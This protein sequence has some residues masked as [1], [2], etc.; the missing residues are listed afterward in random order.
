VR[1]RFVLNGAKHEEIPAPEGGEFDVLLREWSPRLLAQ[2]ARRYGDFALAED[3]VQ[4][5]IIAAANQW[6]VE[7]RPDHPEAWLTRVATRRMI[8]RI[9]S[10]VARRRREA[11]LARDDNIEH[12]TTD[13]APQSQ[14]DDTLDLLIMCCHPAL[15][16][17]SA[18]ALTLRALCGLTTAEIANAF[19]V[20]ESTMAQRIS[21]AKQTIKLHGA[22]FEM[23]SP[24]TRT[25]RLST[26][27]HVLHLMFNEGYVA[28]SGQRAQRLDLTNEA[29]RLMREVWAFAP[30][31]TEAA[32]LLALMLLTDARR[33]ARVDAFGALVP[34]LDQDRSAWDH[35][36]IKE[37]ISLISD[38]LPKG[39]VGPYQ[40]MAA[41]AAVHDEADLAEATDWAQIVVLY[42][43]LKR[44][45]DNPMVVLNQAVAVAMVSGARAGLSLLERLA[46]DSRLTQHHRLDAVRAHLLERAGDMRGA[47]EH[48]RRAALHTGSIPERDF[49]L[50]SAARLASAVN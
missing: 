34:L 18:M 11:E 21:R 1:A 29:I 32:G 35:A 38:T 47:I 26:V 20:P 6:P 27:L 10:D 16:P 50:K 33:P 3:A 41:I 37:G 9:R 17:P 8:D 40:I 25:E 4:D 15:S 39:A 45:T 5:A 46:D 49:L 14:Q 30:E 13:C 36:L 42:D 7:G 44:M 12:K 31:N 23:P 43:V 22:S 24:A 2:L 19:F 28:T 48:Y